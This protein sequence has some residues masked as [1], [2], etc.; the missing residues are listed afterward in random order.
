MA[1]CDEQQQ[2]IHSPNA[3]IRDVSTWPILLKNTP[4]NSDPAR[5]LHVFRH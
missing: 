4:R 1:G 3:V 2:Y 5:R